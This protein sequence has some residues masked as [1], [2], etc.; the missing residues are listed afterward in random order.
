M[1]LGTNVR[2]RF[3]TDLVAECIE[4]DGHRFIDVIDPDT[5]DAFRFY[6]VE[7]SLACAMDG[8]RDVPG[9]V[10]WAKEELGIEPSRNE[11]EQVITTLGTL[12]YLERGAARPGAVELGRPG[13]PATTPPAAMPRS[14]IELGMAGGTPTA[15]MEPLEHEDVEL[16][17]PGAPPE[18][19]PSL[20]R[21][22]VPMAD[23]DGPTHLPQPR[24]TDFDDEV[25]VDLSEHISI[26]PSDV[27]E[28]VRASRGMKAVEVPPELLDEIGDKEKAAAAAARDAA[29]S[30]PVEMEAEPPPAPSAPARRLVEP[31]DEEP[32][33]QRPPVELPAKPVVVT[34]PAEKAPEKPPEKPV[35]KAAEKAPVAHAR[36]LAEEKPSGGVSGFLIALLILVILGAGA[37]FVWKYVLDKKDEPEAVTEPVTEPDTATTAGTGAGTATV[38]EP[39]KPVG[40]PEA[41]LEAKGEPPVEVKAVKAG[42]VVFAVAEGAEVQSGDPIVELQGAAAIKAKLGDSKAGLIWDIETRYPREIEQATKK[43]E[44]AAAAGNAAAVK[45]AERKIAERTTRLEQQKAYA[46]ELREKLAAFTVEAPISGT[47]T[48]PVKKGARIA[49]DQVV[50]TV[51]GGQSLIATFEVAETAKY[52]P[53][54]SVRVASKDEPDQ[55]ANCA[56]SGIEG[57]R[58]TVTCAADVGIPAGTTVVLEN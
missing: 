22:T 43:K 14:D 26:R 20:R 55:K 19:M 52:E 30:A 35:E 8:E 48:G 50:A 47:V 42:V 28:A 23:E 3:R 32:T 46:D 57:A 1:E 2:P 54:Q 29:R 41:V 17:M 38:A 40:P 18:P 36:P 15:R 58:V 27:K 25:S 16:G 6:E 31:G 39:P 53:D 21:S 10:Q 13:A 51:S 49:A 4:A 56:V 24:A 5:G 44:Q 45:A 7:Y 11:L 9:L 34:K 12:G 33:T 37:F